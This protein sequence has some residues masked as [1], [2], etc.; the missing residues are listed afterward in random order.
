[1]VDRIDAVRFKRMVFRASKGNAWIVMSDIEY[2]RIDTSL[3]TPNQLAAAPAD[4][5]ASKDV[6][7]P[8]TVFMIVYSGGGSDFM[9]QKL[10]KICDSFN[11][12]KF[13]LPEDPQGLITK[14]LDL[15]HQLNECDNVSFL[16]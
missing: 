9:R 13:M 12:S 2:S 6:Q 11:C 7:Q 3:E 16:P 1:M 5:A 8:R 10:N 4:K 14:A 15:D